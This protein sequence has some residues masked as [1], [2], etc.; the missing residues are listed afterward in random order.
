MQMHYKIVSVRVH[1][2]INLYQIRKGTDS[3][4][5]ECMCM[6]CNCCRLV[7]LKKSLTN[8]SPSISFSSQPQIPASAGTPVLG[9]A[10]T[11]L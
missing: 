8:P 5:E 4:V 1:N 11:L 3:P 7:F 10:M 9:L 2:Q 6:C